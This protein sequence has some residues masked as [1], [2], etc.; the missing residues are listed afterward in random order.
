MLTDPTLGL[1]AR[2]PAGFTG[3]TVLSEK[4]QRELFRCWTAGTDAHEAL[5][6]ILAQAADNPHVVV[7]RTTCARTCPASAAYVNHVLDP[8]GIPPRMLRSTLL[9]DLVNTM[10]PKLV[11][12]AFGMDAES[13]MIYLADHVH[14][15]HLPR[16]A[17]DDRAQ[18]NHPGRPQFSDHWRAGQACR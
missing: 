14:E 7:T 1:S 15:H 17:D 2:R 18:I 12:V 10:D 16:K 5:L 11:A 8:C 9:A 13:V 3:Q 4:K 6:G